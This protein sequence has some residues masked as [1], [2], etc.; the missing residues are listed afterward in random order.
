MPRN[1]LKEDIREGIEEGIREDIKST[2]AEGRI[3][4]TLE[5]MKKQK[6]K[7]GYTNR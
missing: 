7:L 5:E 1:C 2:C 6:L 4:M 3:M